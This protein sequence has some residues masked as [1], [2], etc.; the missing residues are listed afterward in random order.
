MC[1]DKI[2][3]NE[4]IRNSLLSTV[5][6]AKPN[7][8]VSPCARFICKQNEEDENDEAPP[9]GVRIFLCCRC[10]CV[11]FRFGK[12]IMQSIRHF[13]LR[14]HGQHT[15]RFMCSPWMCA[16][17]SGHTVG[18]VLLD[19]LLLC[20][21]FI[22]TFLHIYFHLFRLCIY[23]LL[24]SCVM[25]SP[26]ILS[27]TSSL[28]LLLAHINRHFII[29]LHH[30]HTHRRISVHATPFVPPFRTTRCISTI[31]MWCMA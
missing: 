2:E 3:T 8:V 7:N 28:P 14:F 23:G 25:P 15:V 12:K 29:A 21:Q 13:W 22:S 10:W 18:H 5:D 26:G 30:T 9:V 19:Q 24:L 27:A 16:S 20:H 17:A 11:F 1:E 31:S 6:C 4:D